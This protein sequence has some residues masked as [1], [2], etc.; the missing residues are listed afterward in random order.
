MIRRSRR[1]RRERL[2]CAVAALRAPGSSEPLALPSSR[3]PLP[4]TNSGWMK[5]YRPIRVRNDHFRTGRPEL[6]HGG[7]AT[8]PLCAAFRCVATLRRRATRPL[9]PAGLSRHARHGTARHGTAGTARPRHGTARPQT[10]SG[11]SPEPRRRPSSRPAVHPAVGRVRPCP[12][13]NS[14]CEGESRLIRTRE[15]FRRARGPELMHVGGKRR[16]TDPPSRDP[17]SAPRPLEVPQHRVGG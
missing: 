16:V 15:G 14:G 1:S 7:R 5:P 13:S 2:A 8:L 3:Y 12:C 4:G 17:G 11:R 10:A 9:G 6:V